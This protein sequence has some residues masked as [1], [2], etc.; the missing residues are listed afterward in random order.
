MGQNKVNF[1]HYIVTRKFKS[2]LKDYNLRI[3]R[4]LRDKVTI[5]H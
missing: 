2:F 1:L 3:T 4:C 5:E